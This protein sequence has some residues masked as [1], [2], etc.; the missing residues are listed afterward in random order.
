MISGVLCTLATLSVAQIKAQDPASPQVYLPS[1][2]V[3]TTA[4]AIRTIAPDLATVRFEFTGRDSTPGRAAR[5]AAGVGEAVRNAV[6]K[7]GVP[8]DSILGRGS[9][10]Y[11]S[12]QSIQMEIKPNAEFRRY[13]TTYVFRDLIEVRIRNLKQVD[14]VI[15]AA[16]DAGAQ[17]LVFL[18]FSSSRVEQVGQEALEEATRQ[19]R[20]NADLMARA[21]GG[22]LGRP[23]QL[24]TQREPSCESWY[25]VRGSQPRD[26]TYDPMAAPPGAELR[27]S[28][29]GRWELLAAADSIRER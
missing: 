2:E 12:D 17:K 26:L 9:V 27:A 24:T 6:A 11:P 14:R 16:L 29:T 25:N 21:S 19:A 8:E 13:D 22:R 23:L 20:H 10:P 1:T 4:T 28:V 5:A 3:R 18:Q 7:V 15:G